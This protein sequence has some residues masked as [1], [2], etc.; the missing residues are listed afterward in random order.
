MNSKLYNNKIQSFIRMLD[1]VGIYKFFLL[2][3]SAFKG[4]S[5]FLVEFCSGFEEVLAVTR[6]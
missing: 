3:L 2:S 5:A 1:D 4:I 6:D